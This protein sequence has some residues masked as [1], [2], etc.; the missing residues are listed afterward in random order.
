MP[1][2]HQLLQSGLSSQKTSSAAAVCHCLFGAVAP[3]RPQ[4]RRHGR[5]TPPR[6][7]Q[8]GAYTGGNVRLREVRLKT[9]PEEGFIFVTRSLKLP[10]NWWHQ[11]KLGEVY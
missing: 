11:T 7:A 3:L 8:A 1:V 4:S 6:R 10:V 5:F 9:T 2:L